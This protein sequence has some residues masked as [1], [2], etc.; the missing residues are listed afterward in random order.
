MEWCKFFS[1]DEIRRSLRQQPPHLLF[2]SHFF[3]SS[4][5][6]FCK[7]V[8]YYL[9]NTVNRL[10]KVDIFVSH[11]CRS[12]PKNMRETKSSTGRFRPIRFRYQRRFDR[13]QTA[14][15]KRNA[16][17]VRMCLCEIAIGPGIAD[18]T[19]GPTARWC[20]TDCRIHFIDL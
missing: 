3:F 6:L 14:T 10:S 7:N 18:E 19:F 9:W 15:R 13:V 20:R 11:L 8:N 17:A 4:T 12:P 2:K 16:R 5:F 1:L